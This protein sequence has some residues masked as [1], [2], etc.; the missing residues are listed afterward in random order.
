MK[1]HTKITVFLNITKPHK[2]PQTAQTLKIKALWKSYG[3][4]KYHEIHKPS[5]ANLKRSKA[6]NYTKTA[7]FP[8][9]TK[10]FKKCLNHQNS[11]NQCT[12]KEMWI[13][14]RS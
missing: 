5:I 7:V 12:V 4:P 14:L 8:K 6:K 10:P 3:I 11:K 13:P 9:I 2:N 1:N